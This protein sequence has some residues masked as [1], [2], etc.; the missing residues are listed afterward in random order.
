MLY[1]AKLAVCHKIHTNHEMQ[2]EQQADFL[3]VKAGGTLSNYQATK[4]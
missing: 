3:N 2:R 1:T 4:F